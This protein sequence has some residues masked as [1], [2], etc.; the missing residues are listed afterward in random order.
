[1]PRTLTLRGT[2]QAATTELL[3]DFEGNDLT[4]AWKIQ[5][6]Q[7]TDLTAPDKGS[8]GLIV[9]TDETAKIVLDFSDNQVIGY[10]GGTGFNLEVTDPN[11]V[12]VNEL[13]GTALASLSY[14]ITIEEITVD[15][16]A[17]TMYQ[18]KERAQGPPE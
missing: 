2:F 1:M 10:S 8:A 17:N 11:H 16:T 9:H 3:F 7:V 6:I 5:R 15:A 4:R 13:Y 12:I 18:L 14:L